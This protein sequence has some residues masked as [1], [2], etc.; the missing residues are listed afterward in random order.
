MAIASR[1]SRLRSRVRILQAALPIALASF[2]ALA[3]GQGVTTGSITGFVTDSAGTPLSDATVVATHLPSGTRYRAVVR[4]SGAY[5]LPNL[6]VGAPYRVTATYLGYQPVTRDNVSVALGETQRVD[7][8]LGRVATQLGAVRVSAQREEG[9][10]RTGAATFIDSLQVAALPSV[11]R[12]TRDLTRLDPRSDGNFA[13]AGRNWLYNSISLD[14]S[15]FSNSFG[16]DDPAPGGQANAE[17]VPFDA[18]AQVQVA[19]APFDVRQSGFTGASIN[20]VTKSGTNDFRGSVYYFGRNDALQGNT[21]SGS[22]VAANPSLKFLQSGLSVSG[23]IIK[24]KLFFFANG[25]VERTD[26]PG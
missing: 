5:T 23:P 19:I 20:T 12:S 9:G 25:E 14:G 1:A 18:V 13:F 17:P 15:Y 8:R 26:D 10:A 16:L 2:P 22:D 4:G 21:V 24:N 11:K 7:F 3:L 6:R